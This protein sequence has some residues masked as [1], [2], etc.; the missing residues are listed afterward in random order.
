[1]H[2]C[3]DGRRRLKCSCNDS[4]AADALE[5]VAIDS[6]DLFCNDLLASRHRLSRQLLGVGKIDAG[7]DHHIG[8]R[9]PENG[10]NDQKHYFFQNLAD[11]C[12]P[13]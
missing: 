4:L 11:A 10:A 3:A 2:G 8:D 5:T 7:L 9:Q 13:A 1:M 12:R 6:L